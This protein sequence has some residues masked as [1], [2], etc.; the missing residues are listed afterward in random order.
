M[1]GLNT[2]NIIIS[3]SGP[4]KSG[5]SVL[6]QKVVGKDYLIRVF[7]PQIN[8]VDGV[9][10]AV[11]NWIESPSATSRQI[12]TTSA[13]STKSVGQ[14]SLS[15]PGVGGLGGK[16]E[17]ADSSASARTYGLTHERAGL[18]QVKR[19]I[20]NSDFVVFID[21][22]HY[23]PRE[24]Q[25]DVAKQLK[26]AAELGIKI[27]TASVPHRSDDIVRA[28]AEL[29]GRVLAVDMN[30]WTQPELIRIAQE[31]FPFLNMVVD[32]GFMARLALEA[33][34]SPQLMQSL[35]LQ[36]CSGSNINETEETEKFFAFQEAELKK[37]LEAT[38]A[39]ADF[40]TLVETMHI[41]PK[42]RGQ[43]RN[44]YPFI[45][46]T[47][48]DVYRAVLMAIA[49]G[50]PAMSFPYHEL[51]S[52]VRKVCADP[53][54]VPVGSSISEACSQLDKIAKKSVETD[55]GV[56]G[57]P[58]VEW[59]TT[60]DVENLHVAEPYFLFYLRASSKL[61]NLGVIRQHA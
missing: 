56:Q 54:K 46:G 53:D 33:C 14:A 8:T 4:S 9:W 37:I 45:D 10:G 50:P 18:I 36:T 17:T 29:R 40:S 11:L 51:L 43:D 49:D 31:G 52:R 19:E 34:G 1:N 44:Q 41:G 6:L 28:N 48:G 39:L 59:D 5:K 15:L 2:P 21:D 42:S 47:T 57:L 32:Q 12:T 27:C 16:Y 61:K 58:P 35:C 23:M 26:A 7:G 22:F 38:S 55:T 20:A 3:V 25:V 13:A 30:Y 60:A 24:L